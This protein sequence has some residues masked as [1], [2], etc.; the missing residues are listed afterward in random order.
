MKKIF[1]CAFI[2]FIINNAN[3]QIYSQSV[4]RDRPITP[5][6]SSLGTAMQIKQRNYNN[7]LNRVNSR[8]NDIYSHFD[9]LDITSERRN[10]LY[11]LFNDKC[12][13]KAPSIDYSSNSQTNYLINALIDCANLQMKTN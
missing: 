9:T 11:I 1:I 5:N 13:K 2:T 7:N 6:I 12:V 10:N 3:S 8:I 4:T